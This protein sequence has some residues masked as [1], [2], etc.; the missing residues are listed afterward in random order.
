MCQ[1]MFWVEETEF[2]SGMVLSFTG[3]LGCEIGTTC[4]TTKKKKRNIR[5]R[6][7]F[8]GSSMVKNPPPKQEMQEMQ[9]QSLGWEDPLK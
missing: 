8:P 9:L 1:A 4:A 7:G 3:Y 2:E 5:G 6:W